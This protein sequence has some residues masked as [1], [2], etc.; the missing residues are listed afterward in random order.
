MEA[1]GEYLAG[2]APSMVNPTVYFD[3][4]NSQIKVRSRRNESVHALIAM[5]QLMS[6]LAYLTKSL[7]ETFQ[8]DSRGEDLVLACV[9]LLQDCPTHHTSGRRVSRACIQ[10]VAYNLRNNHRNF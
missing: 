1:M 9:R 8:P 5:S 2:A 4:V 10:C 3:Y 7:Q 6:F